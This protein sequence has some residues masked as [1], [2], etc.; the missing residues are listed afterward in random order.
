MRT[1]TTTRWVHERYCD[2]VELEIARFVEVVR[3]ADPATPV[4]ICG[5]WT[6]A[7][8]VRHH[9]TTH[10]WVRYVVGR[11]AQERIWSGDVGIG[12]P[13]RPADYPAWL[14]AGAEPLL[15]TLRGIRPD[16]PVWAVGADRQVGFWPRRVLFEA[17]VHRADAELA[18]GREP[19]IEPETAADGVDEFL[20]NLPYFR[21]VADRARRM[22]C[23]G[24]TLRLRA[25]DHDSDWSITLRS[26]GFAWTRERADA[27]AAIEGRASDLLL[28]V[29]GRVPSTD[30]RFTVSGDAQ[31]LERWQATTAP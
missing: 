11:R 21:W 18:L 13:A 29:Y 31:L 28:F 26:D 16:T 5:G 7:D 19:H 30:A 22:H 1:E 4:P 12:L 17:V 6:I 14:A 2:A 25:V 23:D 8:L 3:D 27:D 10:R 15:A 24:R 20:T 9:R